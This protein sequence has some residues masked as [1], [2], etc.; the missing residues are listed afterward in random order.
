MRTLNPACEKLWILMSLGNKEKGGKIFSL[1]LVEILF[2]NILPRSSDLVQR[3]MYFK[4]FHM[5][6]KSGLAPTWPSW[7]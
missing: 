4:I 7:F 6:G 3:I 5:Q 2:Q 1:G